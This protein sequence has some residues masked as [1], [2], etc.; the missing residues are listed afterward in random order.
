MPT[1]GKVRRLSITPPPPG[2]IGLSV[3]NLDTSAEFELGKFC[4]QKENSS[5]EF[6]PGPMY[7]ERGALPL[8]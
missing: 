3:F 7:Y 4:A 8:S 2:S 6:N 5:P 1:E